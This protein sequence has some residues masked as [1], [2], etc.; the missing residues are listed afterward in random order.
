MDKTWFIKRTNPEF[1]DYLSR[2]SSISP[3]TAQVLIN[4]G[5]NTPE[6]VN[7]FFDAGT[8]NLIEPCKLPGM[9]RAIHRIRKAAHAGESILVHGDYDADGITAT[10]ILLLTLKRAGIRCDHFIPN[11]FNHGY[12]FNSSAID[13]ARKNGASLIITV[14]CGINAFDEVKEASTSGLDV[15]ITD[16]HE[17]SMNKDGSFFLPEAHAVV[18]PKLMPEQDQLP[19]SGAGIALKIAQG[20]LGLDRALEFFDLAAI[21]TIA[22]MVPLIGDNRIIIRKGLELINNNARYSI[23]TLKD[24]SSLRDRYV[25]TGHL[26]YSL[27]PRVNA[28]GR[29]S[30]ASDVVRFFISDNRDEISRD[31]K[32]LNI[33]NQRR[34]KIE[35]SVYKEALSILKEKGTGNCIILINTDWH[36]GVIGI[37]ASRIVEAF[38]RPAFVFSVKDGRARGSARS[39]P[40]FDICEGLSKCSDLLIRYGGH[41]QAAGLTLNTDNMEIFEQRMNEIVSDFMNDFDFSTDLLIDSEVHLRDITFPLLKELSRIEPFGNGN[42]EPLFASRGLNVL[43][44]QIVGGNHL[45]MKLR[46]DSYAID[47][48]GFNMGGIFEHLTSQTEIDVAFVPTI[49]DWNGSKRLQLQIKALRYPE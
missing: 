45:K 17:P 20:L 40:P 32:T 22:D 26:S 29:I 30:D 24:I 8:D 36:E 42:E 25:S 16:H 37:V 43:S 47:A 48:I 33:N 5:I 2:S 18:N 44:P 9:E 38:R 23:E 19:L 15:I 7:N 34:K 46:N 31:A 3:I 49:N 11:R 27:I 13:L 35:E 21:G 10:S 6:Q 28:T 12:G 4:R 1:V 41:K 39:V 14:D